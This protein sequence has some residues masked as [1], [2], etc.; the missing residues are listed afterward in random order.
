ML[1]WTSTL[2]LM[3]CAGNPLNNLKE[4]IQSTL[5]EKL[6]VKE[7]DVENQ[8]L[9]V[10]NAEETVLSLAQRQTCGSANCVNGDCVQGIA[11]SFCDCH[12][13]WAGVSCDVSGGFIATC[14]K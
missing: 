4:R 10:L 6:H 13:G 2:L 12:N 11:T 5:L 1:F 3:G 8:L 14:F 9:D 7:K